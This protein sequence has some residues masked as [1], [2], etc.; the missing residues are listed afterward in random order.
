MQLRESHSPSP[1]GHMH[2]FA[3]PTRP[4]GLGCWAQAS[5]DPISGGR[6]PSHVE[7]RPLPGPSSDPGG[8]FQPRLWCRAWTEWQKPPCCDLAGDAH[9]Y[10]QICA[11]LHLQGR[12][13]GCPGAPRA[14]LLMG[15][16]NGPC[17]LGRGWPGTPQ[18]PGPRKPQAHTAPWHVTVSKVQRCISRLQICPPSYM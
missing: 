14:L 8:C 7:G 16:W 11:C 18:P 6:S 13:W 17:L 9:S 4:Q 2:V 15:C 12:A 1:L 10:L 3:G 5:A